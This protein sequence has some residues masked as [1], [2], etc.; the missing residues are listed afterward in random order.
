MDWQTTNELIPSQYVVE[1]SV[2][3][4][5]YDLMVNVP[6]QNNGQ[7]AYTFVD[8]SPIVGHN[9]YRIK[10]LEG[11]GDISYSD[12]RQSLI[13]SAQGDVIMYPNPVSSKL[14]IETMTDAQFDG[15]IEVYN[16]YGRLMTNQTFT[17]DQIR[18]EVDLSNLPS[19]TFILRLTTSNGIVKS[20]KVNRS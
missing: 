10:H 17:K 11:N 20:L 3:G 13:F 6:S 8:D 2:D 7:N 9:F 16:S 4:I 15:T 19:G 5:N 14:Y 12:I 18:Y 1:H